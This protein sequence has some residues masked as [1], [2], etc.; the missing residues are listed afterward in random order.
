VSLAGIAAGVGSQI[1][2]RSLV[3]DLLS[4]WP[5]PLGALVMAGVLVRRGGFKNRLMAVPGL[6]VFTW[7]LLTVSLHLSGAAWLPSAAAVVDG[8]SAAGVSTASMEVDLGGG[9][10]RLTTG[11]PTVLYRVGPILRGGTTGAPEVLEQTD[12][13]AVN[14]VVVGR[15][16]SAWFRF[17]G[18]S[19]RLS[20]VPAWQ[21]E[22][23]AGHILATLGGAEPSDVT[24]SAPDIDVT[25]GPRTHASSLV[26]DGTAKVHVPPD[27]PVVVTGSATVPDGWQATGDGFRSPAGDGGWT[28][29]VA[30][31]SSVTVMVS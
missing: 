4:L 22:V 7:I 17:L 23:T 15:N 24:L 14:T 29:A 28:I 18:W 11:E 5:V 16:D 1:L 30:D 27:L 3:L 13:S 20:D 31:G 25:L 6:L 26:L 9:T 19:L 21:V 12:G 8:P 2:S 10:L